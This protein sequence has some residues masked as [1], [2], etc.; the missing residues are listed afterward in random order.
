MPA[1]MVAQIEEA[2]HNAPVEKSEAIV[3]PLHTEHV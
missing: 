3:A 1:A 2:G